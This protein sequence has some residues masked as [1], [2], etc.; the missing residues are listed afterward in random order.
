MICTRSIDGAVTTF[1]IVAD[2]Q[3]FSWNNLI[4]EFANLCR[5]CNNTINFQASKARSEFIQM[6]REQEEWEIDEFRG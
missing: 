4:L 5:W 2:V 1:A 6:K 3:D